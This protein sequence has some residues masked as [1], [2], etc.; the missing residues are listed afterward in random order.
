MWPQRQMVNIAINSEKTEDGWQ[1]IAGKE[2]NNIKD[3]GEEREWTYDD[4]GDS[5]VVKRLLYTPK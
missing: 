3:D 1:D 4:Q 5:L 2:S